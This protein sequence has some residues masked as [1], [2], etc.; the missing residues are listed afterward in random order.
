VIALHV[1]MNGFVKKSAKPEAFDTRA[2]L[3]AKVTV[4]S[5]RGELWTALT[6]AVAQSLFCTIFQLSCWVELPTEF[7][8]LTHKVSV[9][10]A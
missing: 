1:A 8:H 5:A 6:R 3:S 2:E 4:W 9:Y 10:P 7:S